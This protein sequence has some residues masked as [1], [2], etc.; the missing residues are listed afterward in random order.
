MSCFT[1]I[2]LRSILQRF[3]LPTFAL[4]PRMG[5]AIAVLKVGVM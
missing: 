3:F 5:D 2:Q 1:C 4:S